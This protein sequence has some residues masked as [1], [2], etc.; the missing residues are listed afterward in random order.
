LD[1]KYYPGGTFVIEVKNNSATNRYIQSATLDG[2]PLTKCWF[3]HD[4]LVDGGSLVLEMGAEPN[5][6]WGCGPG[7]APPSMSI[8]ID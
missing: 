8:P 7:D 4:E 3:Y 2:K 6:S 5:Q 1:P